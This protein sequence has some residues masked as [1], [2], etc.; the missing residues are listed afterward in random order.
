MSSI[1]VFYIPFGVYYLESE[2]DYTELKKDKRFTE[3]H[4]EV[5]NNSGISHKYSHCTN[6]LNDYPNLAKKVK[7]N[8][9]PV[10]GSVAV[11]SVT[12]CTACK[13]SLESL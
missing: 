12:T 3:G 8:F 5:I 6:I 11:V 7:L 2:Y 10:S 1:P 13:Q 9:A 4:S